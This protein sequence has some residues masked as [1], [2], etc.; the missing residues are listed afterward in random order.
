MKFKYNSLLLIIIYIINSCSNQS[1]E[2][3]RNDNCLEKTTFSNPK[4]LTTKVRYYLIEKSPSRF[5]FTLEN[6]E[7]DTNCI[8]NTIDY[9]MISSSGKYKKKE[10]DDIFYL[11]QK[12]NFLYLL[13]RE[14]KSISVDLFSE[15]NDT[16]I[17]ITNLYVKNDTV[18]YSVYSEWNNDSVLIKKEDRTACF[19]KLRG[20]Q[21]RKFIKIYKMKIKNRKIDTISIVDDSDI[22]IY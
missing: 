16:L 10:K 7:I 13:S 14:N 3:I 15:K 5:D 12:N 4:I 22:V 18:C 8:I 21:V 2:N 1:N 11:S 19:D 17:F 6:V 20:T 9:K